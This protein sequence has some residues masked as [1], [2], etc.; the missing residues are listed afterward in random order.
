VIKCLVPDLPAASALAPWLERID[1]ECWYTNFGPLMAEFE[2]AV[3]ALLSQPAAHASLLASGTAAL[4]LGLTALGIGAGKRVLMPALTFPATA[5]AV[6]RC[7]AQTVFTDVC[8]HTWMLTPDI[9]RRCAERAPI[10]LVMPVAAFGAPLPAV[11]WDRFVADTGIAVLADAAGTFGT[12]PVGG[13]LHWAFSLHATKPFGI[14]EGGV[15]ASCDA[16]LVERVRVLSNFGFEAGVI[17]AEG[18]TNAKLSEYA[19]AVALAQLQRWPQICARRGE[20]FDAYCRRLAAIA[21]V[22][23]QA[24]TT[25]VP[26]MLCLRVATDAARLL[27]FMKTAGIECRRWYLPPLHRHPAFAGYS[28]V[29]I[30]GDAHLPVTEVLARELIGLPFHTWLTDAQIGTVTA[31]LGDGL[32]CLAAAPGS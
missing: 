12:Q 13:R 27:E 14:G 30:D 17:G 10:D 22:T 23:L 32:H 4:E 5:L 26:A 7:G 9:A 2:A 1:R 20:V 29:G 15:F 19:A 28:C 18:G 3:P 31:A 11:A 24:H 6:R 25:A 21:G 16:G 8:P